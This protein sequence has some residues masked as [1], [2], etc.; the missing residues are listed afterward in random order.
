MSGRRRDA[1]GGFT[2]LEVMAALA[3]FL[4][5]IVS[6]LSLFTSGTTLHL[7]SQNLVVT[8]DLVEEALELAQREVSAATVS[9]ATE[10]PPSPPLRALP[11]RPDFQYSW[12][13]TP[14]P[15]LGVW[16]MVVQIVWLEGG[17]VRKIEVERVLPRLKSLAAEAR[18]I[19]QSKR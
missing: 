13:V 2:L 18:A 15:D 9:P 3:I 19:V 1:R 12:N 10:A 14:A 8:N 11:G 17:K 6:V 7:D 16:R 5:G 4:I